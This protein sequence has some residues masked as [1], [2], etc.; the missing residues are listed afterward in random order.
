[1]KN[2]KDNTNMTDF[3]NDAES[4]NGISSSLAI[5]T[6]RLIGGNRALSIAAHNPVGLDGS[7]KFMFEVQPDDMVRFFIKNKTELLDFLTVQTG[8]NF[9]GSIVA[10]CHS[11]M[12]SNNE[13]TMKDI[14]DGLYNNLTLSEVL[15]PDNHSLA[16]NVRLVSNFLYGITIEHLINCYVSYFGLV[17]KTGSSG[18]HP[19]D[20]GS[21]MNGKDD[22]LEEIFERMGGGYGIV[23]LSKQCLNIDCK[24]ICM[25]FNNTTE[26]VQFFEK[27]K[28]DIVDV[29][30]RVGKKNGNDTAVATI[31][32]YAKVLGHKQSDIGR[33][34]YS[35]VAQGEKPS[36]LKIRIAK[37]A[38]NLVFMATAHDYVSYCMESASNR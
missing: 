16:T 12:N 29:I 35:N 22:L 31:W 30:K 27:Y 5:E 8:D 37:A 26:I 13:V 17:R 24:A 3:L 28:D 7:R 10:Y 18:D 1:M 2:I 14:A 19:F 38:V 21:H 9:D 23:T 6:T 20:V 11:Y 25:S 32:D 36:R 33:G 4:L 34:I 15:F